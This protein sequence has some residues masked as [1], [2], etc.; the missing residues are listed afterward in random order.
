MTFN[1]LVYGREEA[2]TNLLQLLCDANANANTRG[3]LLQILASY[4][5]SA[6]DNSVLFECIRDLF[7][8]DPKQILT[9]L[10]AALTRRGFPDISCGA[11]AEPP[12]VNAAAAFALAEELLRASH[13]E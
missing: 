12:R 4:R 5:W 8:H 11:L 2:E 6:P 13:T 1:E 7:M 9:H 10:P 3:R